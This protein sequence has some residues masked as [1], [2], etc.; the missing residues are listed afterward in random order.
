[1]R[2]CW[3]SCAHAFTHS[4]VI[5]QMRLPCP[6]AGLCRE[7]KTCSTMFW[8]LLIVLHY[9]LYAR[10][11]YR[12]GVALVSRKQCRRRQVFVILHHEQNLHTFFSI[13][14]YAHSCSSQPNV[15]LPLPL[16]PHPSRLRRHRQ[17]PPAARHRQRHCRVNGSSRCA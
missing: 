17:Q 3:P 14:F 10:V 12:P 7:F 1:M 6:R 8:F 15:G 16:V 11:E 13:K 4:D 9:F 5:V 2:A